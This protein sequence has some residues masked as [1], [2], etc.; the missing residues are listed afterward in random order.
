MLRA[1]SR[2]HPLPFARRPARGRERWLFRRT[3]LR[4][5]ATTLGLL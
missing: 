3:P 1:S 4:G 5:T 2:A